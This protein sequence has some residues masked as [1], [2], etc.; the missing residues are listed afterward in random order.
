[1]GIIAIPWSF[2]IF[3]GFSSDNIKIFGQKRRTHIML[4]TFLCSVS[5]IAL[6][7]FGVRFGKYFVTFCVFL[8]QY[9]M[10]YNDTVTD[11]LTVQASKLG[12]PNGCEWLNGICY[13]LQGFGAITGALM[14]IFV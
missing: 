6:M 3:Y 14:A 10:A 11:A 8:S 5:M 12:I 1:M 4:N 7:L 9:T 13:S 2:K